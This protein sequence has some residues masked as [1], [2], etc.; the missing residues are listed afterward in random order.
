MKVLMWI[1]VLGLVFGLANAWAADNYFITVTGTAPGWQSVLSG[2]PGRCWGKA[3]DRVFLAGGANE[4]AWLDSYNIAYSA[5]PNNGE[6]LTLYLCY[7]ASS[8]NVISSAD[9]LTSGPGY[10][11][12]GHPV[13]A[14]GQYR[15]L[16]LR[17]LTFEE[18]SLPSEIIQI[19]DSH[20]DSLISHVSRDTIIYYLTCL[21]GEAP[22]EINGGVDT[23]DT[24]YSGTYYN[25]LAAQYLKERLEGYGYQTEYHNFYGGT[26]RHVAAFDSNRAWTVTESSEALRTTDGGTTWVT[27]PDN[28][29]YELWG[30]E[31]IGPD[32]V[33]LAGNY[34]TVRFSTDGGATFANQTT[35]S[36]HY[37]S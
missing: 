19:Y 35:G 2:Y 1:V 22:I 21:S 27:M 17:K 15:A 4:I 10:V 25:R 3:A 16:S 37:R 26:L 24:R 23:L 18:R 33:W 36:S 11:V 29:S 5:V 31:N 14:A 28:S 34:G 12:T 13:T 9:I 32:S 30:A 7:I 8:E 6:A 20:I